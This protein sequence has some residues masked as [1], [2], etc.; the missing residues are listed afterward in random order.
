M[1]S[2]LSSRYAFIEHIQPLNEEDDDD[3]EEFNRKAEILA[4]YKKSFFYVDEEDDNME[5]FNYWEKHNYKKP[6]NK[7]PVIK[8][9]PKIFNIDVNKCRKN[10]LYYSNYD[11]PSYTVMDK[12]E[13]YDENKPL[14]TG[15]YYV[16]TDQYFP[17]RGVGWYSLPMIEYCLENK[18]IKHKDIKYSIKSILSIPST[19]YN[20]F[21]DLCYKSLDKHEDIINFYNELEIDDSNID[22][23]KM[24]VNMM[25]GGFKPN[26]NK[27]IKWLSVCITASSCE[28]YHQFLQIIT[29]NEV[30][31][32]TNV[33]TEK[34]ICDQILDLEAIALHRLSNL[35]KSKMVQF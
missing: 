34:P 29:I 9:Q 10:I 35:I 11:Y 21:I 18:L 5:F 14:R 3:E 16:E 32:S 2:E 8:K 4:E 19:Y 7:K 23:K 13:P 12:V 15:C 6:V 26:L 17:M 22:F 20:E 25:I 33:E 24:A 27:N 31:Q 1:D 30:I 28:A